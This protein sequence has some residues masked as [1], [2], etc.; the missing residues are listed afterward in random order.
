M[1][2]NAPCKHES[3]EKLCPLT[4][5]TDS[6]L[7]EIFVKSE[8]WKQE[9]RVFEGTHA[10]LREASNATET[11]IVGCV[12]FLLVCRVTKSDGFQF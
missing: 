1:F 12:V 4:F 7:R 3:D 11:G 9:L 2:T 10:L 6:H 5:K 8:G